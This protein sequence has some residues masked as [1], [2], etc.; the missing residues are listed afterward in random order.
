MREGLHVQ[1]TRH[2]RRIRGKSNRNSIPSNGS[3][4]DLTFL[5]TNGCCQ[6]LPWRT[7]I[8]P[9]L[10]WVG[11]QWSNGTLIIGINPGGGGYT[12]RR[13]PTDER[14]Y[15]LLRHLRDARDANEQLKRFEEVSAVWIGIQRGHNIWLFIAALLEATRE[16]V[17]E[18]AFM[19]ILPFRTRMDA[20]API[21]TLRA[22]WRERQDRKLRRSSRAAS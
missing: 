4:G 10:V 2:P 5:Q 9:P 7:P 15:S 21:A 3:F 19:N 17:D 18:C 16:T 11:A 22:A 14:L 1:G 13:N 6:S 8:R 20:P 12:Y